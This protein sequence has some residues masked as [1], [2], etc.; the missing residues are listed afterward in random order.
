MLAWARCVCLVN[1]LSLLCKISHERFVSNHT[2]SLLV[3]FTT[4]IGGFRLLPR[5]KRTVHTVA[6]RAQARRGE[7]VDRRVSRRRRNI[8]VAWEGGAPLSDYRGSNHLE[9][10]GIGASSGDPLSSLPKASSLTVSPSRHLESCTRLKSPMRPTLSAKCV[11]ALLDQD[12][13]KVP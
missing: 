6:P 11:L 10:H 7:L 13:N 4:A 8:L 9:E 5:R 3:V 12:R 2:E 1:V